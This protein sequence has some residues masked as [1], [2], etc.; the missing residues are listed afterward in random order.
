[1]YIIYIIIGIIVVL[2]LLWTFAAM[3]A[4]LFITD[5]HAAASNPDEEPKDIPGFV[6]TE[7][8]ENSAHMPMQ[9]EPEVYARA[10]LRFFGEDVADRAKRVNGQP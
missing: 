1:M 4:G 6:R 2:G 3:K 10:V 5:R 9:E 7:L 8:I